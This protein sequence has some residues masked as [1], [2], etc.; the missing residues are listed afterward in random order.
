[1]KVISLRQL[2]GTHREVRCPNGGFTSIRF[3]LERDGMGFSLH[4]TIIPKGEAQHWHYTNHLEA[5][6]CISG[7]GL[8]TS[9]DTGQSWEILPD[10]C[11]VLDDHDD[12][13]FRALE[14]TTLIS[15]FNP[16]VVGTEVH[17]PDGSYARAES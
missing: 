12:H 1:M 7:R 13:F 5:C 15:V 8:L 11:Y 10:T 4:K 17:L 2:L 14:L 16:P 6:Y 3:L 9:A